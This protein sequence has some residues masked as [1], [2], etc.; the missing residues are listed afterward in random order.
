MSKL[1]INRKSVERWQRKLKGNLLIYV[2]R[3]KADQRHADY[4]DWAMREVNR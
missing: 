2:P 4:L 3:P 1:R